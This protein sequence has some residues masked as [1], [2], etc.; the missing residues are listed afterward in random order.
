MKNFKP[1][2]LIG[3]IIIF[4]IM[5]MMFFAGQKEK[6]KIQ[7]VKEFKRFVKAK[8]VTYR[9]I[10]SILESTGRLSSLHQINIISEVQGKILPADISLKRGTIFNKGDILFKIYKKEAALNHK[11]RLSRFLKSVAVLLPDLKV[12]FPKSYELWE[13]FLGKI[14][15]DNDLPKIPK[16]NSLKE[17]IFLASR[18]ILSEY[19][20]IKSEEIRLKKYIIKAPFTGSIIKVNLEVE[21]IANPGSII[22]VVCRTDELELEV[23]IDV[24]FFKWIN[25]GDKVDVFLNSTGHIEGKISRISNVLDPK[26]QNLTVFIHLKNEK[27]LPL[28]NGLYLKAVFKEITFDNCMKIPR[29]AVFNGNTVFIIKNKRLKKK[30]IKIKKI[31][32]DS[33]IFAGLNSGEMIVTESLINAKENSLVQIIK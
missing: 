7:K 8:Q 12:D 5:G 18:N 3:V 25:K 20:Q 27:T 4:A 30:K 17:K 6:P 28:Y 14:E 29:N 16:I 13:S 21:S 1:L 24:K 32:Q 33:I 2:L 10:S 23:P 22:A 15:F 11:A 26:T 19:Y 31:N 9:S